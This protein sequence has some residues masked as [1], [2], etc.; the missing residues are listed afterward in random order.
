ME[1]KKLKLLGTLLM[2]GLI[3]IFTLAV[4]VNVVYIFSMSSALE[5]NVFLKLQA[6]AV[7]LKSYYEKELL[8]TGEITYDHKYVDSLSDQHVELTLFLDDTRYVTSLKNKKGERNEGTKAD[9]TIYKEVLKGNDYHAD[10]VTI[11]NQEYFV[12]YMPLCD[13]DGTVIGMAFAGETEEYVNEGIYDAIIKALSTG[14]FILSVFLGIIIFVSNIIRKRIV[15]IIE[16]TTTIASGDLSGEKEL[17]SSIDELHILA[18]S[19]MSLRGK[20]KDVINAVVTGV[21]N[22]DENLSVVTENVETCNHASEGVLS[23]VDDLSHGTSDMAED[24]QRAAS[25]MESMGNEIDRI[26]ELSKAADVCADEIEKES[27]IAREELRQLLAANQTTMKISGEVTKGIHESAEAVA[28]IETAADMITNITGQTKLLALNA[29]IEAARAGEAGKGFSVVATELSSLA[30]QSNRSSKEI[31][32][33][34]D[35]IIKASDEN[36][37]LSQKIADAIVGEKEVLTKVDA[38]FTVVKEKINDTK[39][40]IYDIAEKTE[41]LNLEKGK[42]L[43]EISSLSAISEENAAACEQTNA[44]MEELGATVADI[45]QKTMNTMEAAKTLKDASSYFKVAGETMKG[46]PC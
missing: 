38:S 36:I 2:I 5:E 1:R 15:S 13:P 6:G 42:M 7:G 30:E 16:E 46:T 31:M 4:L 18:K 14:V 35:T 24:V 22:L 43:E 8:D 40:T 23:A 21:S 41:S 26:S 44:S 17:Y 19:V 39:S 10:G 3:P 34:V 27:D 11:G 45:Y 32:Q 12:Y 20:M 29:S 33:I 25:N 28:M 9:N 37:L